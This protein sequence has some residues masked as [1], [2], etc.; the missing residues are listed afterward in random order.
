MTEQDENTLNRLLAMVQALDYS[1][2]SDGASDCHPSVKTESLYEALAIALRHAITDPAN[3]QSMQE[4]VGYTRIEETG[5]QTLDPLYLGGKLAPK[6]G[7]HG[8]TYRPVYVA[9]QSVSQAPFCW[10][11]QG[12]HEQYRGE[13]AE[14]DAKASAKRIGGDCQAFSLYAV[15][16]TARAPLTKHEIHR[17]LNEAGVQANG[18]GLNNEMAIVRVIEQAHGITALE[19][20]GWARNRDASLARPAVEPLTELGWTCTHPKYGTWFI[21]RAAIIADWKQDH[22][23]AYPNEAEYEPCNDVVEIWRTEQTSWVEIHAYGRQI[24]R[25]N[26]SAHEVAWLQAMS[27]DV[28]LPD[29]L[30]PASKGAT[31]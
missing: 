11:V 10:M 21:S 23:Q 22:K 18:V 13:Y 25:P 15:P 3:R 2:A 19:N 7:F 14:S 26:L 27:R 30:K 4:P 20:S 12:T 1:A 29:A 17:V 28:D 31:H 16:S 5:L 8:A 9:S 6:P 24:K